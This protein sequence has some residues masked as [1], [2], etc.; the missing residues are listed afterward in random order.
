MAR[1]GSLAVLEKLRDLCAIGAIS[2]AMVL[3]LLYLIES[4]AGSNLSAAPAV[5]ASINASYAI[6][7]SWAE[8]YGTAISVLGLAAIVITLYYA[9]RRA[10]ARV[11][12]VWSSKAEEVHARILADLPAAIET[13]QQDPETAQIAGRILGLLQRLQ[14]KDDTPSPTESEQT[15]LHRD[16]NTLISYL[17]IEAARR[18][19]KFETALDEVYADEEKGRGGW[20]RLRRI[21]R[22]EK[23]SKDLGLI[24]KPM[25][26]VATG[27][28]FITLLGWAGD[29]MAQGLRQVLNRLQV[30]AMAQD[31]DAT[32]LQ[33]VGNRLEPPQPPQEALPPSTAVSQPLARAVTEAML[34]AS[35]LQRSAGLHGTNDE[36][37]E[38]VKASLNEQKMDGGEPLVASLRKEVADDLEKGLGDRAAKRIETHVETTIRPHIE[39]LRERDPKRFVALLHR[40][41]QR[42]AIPITPIDAQSKL[43]ARMLDEALGGIGTAPSTELGKQAQ[44][45]VKDFGKETLKTWADSAAKELVARSLQDAAL[46]MVRTELAQKVTLASSADSQRL[47]QQLQSA[48]GHG[49]SPA[50]KRGSDATAAQAVAAALIDANDAH[51]A[52]PILG[53]YDQVFPLSETDALPDH[54]P[55]LGSDVGGLHGDGGDSGSGGIG[56][57]NGR[58]GGGT[59][60]G[61]EGARV[62]TSSASR[63]TR[64]HFAARSARVRGVLIGRELGGR[65]PQIDDIDWRL[66]AGQPTQIQLR[67]H[68]AGLWEALGPYP[69]AVVNQ[70]L[71]YASDGR[72]VAATITPGDGRIVQRNTLLHPALADTPLGCRVV[73]ADRFVDTFTF[74]D[75][76]SALPPEL[77]E[78]S[79]DRIASLLWVKLLGL[80]EATAHE[81]NPKS[82]PVNK[83]RTIVGELPQPAVSFSG[84]WKREFESFSERAERERPGSMRLAKA[85]TDCALGRDDLAECLCSLAGRNLTD[86]AQWVAVDHTSQFR[87]RDAQFGRGKEWLEGTPDKLGLLEFW[88][89]TTFELH[90]PSGESDDGKSTALDFPPAQLANL[91]RSMA[92][93]LPRYLK[94]S[95]YVA[96]YED[97]MGPL[98]DFIV[99]QRLFRTVMEHHA[100]AF[101][102]AKLLTLQAQTRKFVPTQPTVRWE[103]IPSA[104]GNFEKV[105]QKSSGVAHLSY[106]NWR[107]DSER[108]RR[109][110][111]PICDPASL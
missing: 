108:R 80:A 29:P 66:I 64:F 4:I 75:R 87:E 63:W 58:P 90:K 91:R 92:T 39:K 78:L 106:S 43:M 107:E 70:A 22:S 69:A 97:F 50:G 99:L 52:T 53:S 45:L 26:Y 38:F 84:A 36:T 49:W 82:C 9:S 8:F 94:Q 62:Q 3:A 76:S 100:P 73:E 13:A 57:G 101:P 18:E 44:K 105:L 93:L 31:A 109:D 28:L 10:R 37:L 95:L 5:L 7:K 96:H 55:P 41:D 104:E 21:L 65:P 110:K 72:V 77:R 23:F 30:N 11:A 17:A 88:V 102:S 60:A 42:Y 51:R 54:L 16:L 46:P 15:E 103:P 89:H 14:N 71:R 35:L 25:S 98:E 79:G 61:G 1:A 68:V 85:S 2:V 67:V 24:R 6:V 111:L 47:I 34:R 27:L 20:A 74:S 59:Y 33:A 83:V 32:L 81:T 56:G 19:M 40:I 48:Y 12:Q 86:S